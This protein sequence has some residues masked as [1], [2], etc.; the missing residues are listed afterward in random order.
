MLFSGTTPV[1][2]FGGA[3]NFSP[4]EEQGQKYSPNAISAKGA[5]VTLKA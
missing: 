5:E 4:G 2:L 3:K 1:L